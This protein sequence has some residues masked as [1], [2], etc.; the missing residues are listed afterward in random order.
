VPIIFFNPEFREE[1]VKRLLVV[2]DYLNEKKRDAENLSLVTLIGSRLSGLK[3]EELV[4]N[5][6]SYVRQGTLWALEVWRGEW[7]E[8]RME[9]DEG[10]GGG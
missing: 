4:S 7:G 1:A 10:G 3:R 8:R 9:T 5:T 2:A 6:R